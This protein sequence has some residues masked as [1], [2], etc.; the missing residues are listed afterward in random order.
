[1]GKTTLY[2]KNPLTKAYIH[3]DL[4][5]ELDEKISELVLGESKVKLK[6]SFSQIIEEKNK[7][8]DEL[9]FKNRKLLAQ[10]VELENSLENTVHQNDENYIQSLEINLYIVSYLLNQ[11]VGGYKILNNIIKKYQVKYHGSNKLKEAKVQIQTMKN[12][13][14]CSK[15]ISITESF[16]DS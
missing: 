14:E 3:A 8:I 7:K 13:I 4:L 5:K 1:M 15:I 6:R 16:K 2:A 10:F 9:E 12:D 11:K